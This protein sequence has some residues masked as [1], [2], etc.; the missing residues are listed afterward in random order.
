MSVSA[1][2]VLSVCVSVSFNVSV[3]VNRRTIRLKQLHV[4]FKT[5]FVRVDCCIFLAG[6]LNG[7]LIVK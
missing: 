7:A 4:W 6:L 1:S 3:F 2:V 5:L